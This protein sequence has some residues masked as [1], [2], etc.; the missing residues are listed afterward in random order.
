LKKVSYSQ[1]AVQF[2]DFIKRKNA[3]IPAAN[4]HKKV[5]IPLF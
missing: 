2:G 4:K 1:I 3:A 5:K